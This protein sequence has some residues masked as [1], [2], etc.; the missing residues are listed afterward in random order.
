MS[1]FN[2]R[3]ILAAF[4]SLI[5]FF[6]L[7]FCQSRIGWLCSHSWWLMS[8]SL[9]YEY[10][11]KGSLSNHLHDPQNKG[12]IIPSC[13]GVIGK[14]FPYF[15]RPLSC[16]V[17]RLMLLGALN[18]FMSIQKLIMSIKL[19]RQSTSYLI[20]PLQICWLSDL[21]LASILSSSNLQSWLCWTIEHF[22]FC[23]KKKWRSL[24]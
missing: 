11:P 23:K 16:L 14:L 12:K 13:F 1:C 6:I 22:N 5:S 10:A 8:F 9:S 18:T 20:L 19:S 24:C 15:S 2:F 17:C 4:M 3:A 21:F 7:L